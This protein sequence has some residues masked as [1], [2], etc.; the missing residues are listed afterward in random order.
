MQHLVHVRL[1]G[2]PLAILWFDVEG[3]G[4]GV[5]KDA[6]E[7]PS[8]NAANEMTQGFVLVHIAE[9]GPNLCGAVAQPHGFDVA[10]NDEG[11]VVAAFVA[12]PDGRVERV[13]E[14]VDEHPI[15]LG[16]D[17]GQLLLEVED[18]L[19]DGFATEESL[20]GLWPEVLDGALHGHL[21]LPGRLGHCCR[22][23]GWDSKEE[24]KDKLFHIV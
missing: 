15:E 14:A 9:I 10:G 17:G 16:I 5:D 7:L 20:L 13:G 8:D 23:D 4:V 3:V 21:L 2:L 22:C 1:V 24:G 19:F 12:V 11:V 6:G 18:L